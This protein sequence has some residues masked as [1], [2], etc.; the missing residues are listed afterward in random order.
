MTLIFTYKVLNKKNKHRKGF[1]TSKKISKGPAFLV[2]MA[3]CG[4]M[5]NG[6]ISSV[7]DNTLEY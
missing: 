4:T 7:V 2:N 6:F 1:S 5:V 3:D